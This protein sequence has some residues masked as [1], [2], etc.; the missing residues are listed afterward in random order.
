MRFLRPFTVRSLGGLLLLLM[1]VYH[2][3]AAQQPSESSSM[4][5]IADRALRK[6]APSEHKARWNDGLGILLAG[7]DAAWYDTANGRYYEFI[8]R[9]VDSFVASDGTIAEDVRQMGP[10]SRALFGRQ[11]LL[12]YRVTQEKKYYL[13]SKALQ[14]EL[15]DP[16]AGGA[17]SAQAEAPGPAFCPVEPFLAE[18]AS[19]FQEPQDRRKITRQLLLNAQ[20]VQETAGNADRN[21][22]T[23]A[24]SSPSRLAASITA[25]VDT[26]P[27]DPGNDPGRAQLLTVLKRMAA[28]VIRD[29]D[30]H[31]GLWPRSLP[32]QAADHNDD[33]TMAC[34][35]TY[36]LARGVRL[37]Y[38][39]RTDLA[40]AERAWRSIRNREQPSDNGTTVPGTDGAGSE[41]ATA[42]AFLLAASE[43]T[44][45]PRAMDGLGK[46]V[47][48]DA[49]Y[50][51]QRRENAAGQSELF[52][53]KWDDQSNSG[54]S[55]LGHIFRSDGMMTSTLASAPTLAKLRDAQ[56]YLIASPDNT[57]KNP[58]PHF[59]NAADAEP[60]AAWVR[61]G[62]VLLIMENDPANADIPHMDILADR[63]GLHF[64]N[65]LVH[66][67]IGDRF[68][69]GRIEV[70]SPALPFT[71]P[72]VL[73]MKDTCSLKL[74]K[75][76]R[77]LLQWKGDTLMA[78]A[79]YGKGT[80]L[81]VTDPWL[82]NEYTDGRNL[83]AEY[84]NFA[85]GVEL[86]HWLLR[87]R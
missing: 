39:P 67:V 19:V 87:Q 33:S 49:W 29:Q 79:K 47:L 7:V 10:C 68:E 22:N 80:V 62:G 3:V 86:I 69:M 76:A 57:V 50:N 23:A 1:S 30:S 9:S 20:S 26:L 24:S 59:M 15:T 17:L 55:L 31:S 74:S 11:V 77:P 72:H 32:Q 14:D 37:G 54:F 64:N 70:P 2:P 13:A 34:L 60:I 66:H 21:A 40:G 63:F 61:S 81:A 8:L 46:K 71:H 6:F 56:Y 53:Y 58:H 36:A 35:F 83:P 18:Y 42:G 48:L 65:V 16:V 51:S 75:A 5:R 52:H 84:D 78:I 38:L 27:Y 12:L 43:M 4:Q 25:L 73:Y 82:Y 41:P 28:A 45:Q 85:A 44:L